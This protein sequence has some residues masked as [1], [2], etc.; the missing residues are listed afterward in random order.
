[1]TYEAARITLLRLAD[2]LRGLLLNEPTVRRSGAVVLLVEDETTIRELG[3]V[4]LEDAGYAVIEAD[5]AISALQTLEMG[6]QVH[7]LFTDIQMP[8]DLNGLELAHIVA[9]R[10][11]A[12]RLLV[13]SGLVTPH[14]S[15]LPPHGRFI[16]KP[17][18]MEDMLRQ[19][20]ELVAA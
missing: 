5:S 2:A 17:Y 12:V 20:N 13:S 8:G 11:P 10:W 16:A 15:G 9:D 14:P 19:V 7:V 6:A 4:V 1:M 18:G 3:A